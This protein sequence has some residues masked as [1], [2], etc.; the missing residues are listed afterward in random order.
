MTLYHSGVV[1][2]IPILD[3]LAAP[4]LIAA[5]VMI[6]VLYLSLA[7]RRGSL[8]L[9]LLILVSVLVY[10]C[11]EVIGMDYQQS[12]IDHGRTPMQFTHAKL[13]AVD[14]ALLLVPVRGQ[15]EKDVKSM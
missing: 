13:L 7:I 1:H 5:V 4:L 8:A 2:S 9:I 6:Y 15:V 12:T 3:E 10:L 14:I 11:D